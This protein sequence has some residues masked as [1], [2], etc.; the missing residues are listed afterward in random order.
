[1]VRLKRISIV[2]ATACL[3]AS[4]ATQAALI[5]RGGG[6]LYDDVLNVTWLQDANYAKTS[7]YDADG[8]MTWNQA[9]AWADNLIYHD[10]VRN[11]DYSDWR[12]PLNSPVNGATWNYGYSEDGSTDYGF[13][14]TSVNSEL[15]YM[16]YVDL[17]LQ[18]YFSPSGVYQ[19]GYGVPGSGGYGGQANVGPVQNL[20]S[21]IY[22]SGTTYAPSPASNAWFFSIYGGIQDHADRSVE[23]CAWAVRPGDVAAAPIDHEAPEPGSL[24]LAGLGLTGLG[25]TRRR[26]ALN[27]SPRLQ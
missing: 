20:Q 15:A 9:T 12:L 22:W 27:E 25:W 3:L 23:F 11:V 6:L 19:P 21:C 8:R 26:R 17:G 7:G 14:I 10:S 16:Y 24:V 2:L 5:D 18:G 13:N 4:G 1:M